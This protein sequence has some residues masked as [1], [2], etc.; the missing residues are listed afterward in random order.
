[1]TERYIT[2]GIE[3]YDDDF[4]ILYDENMTLEQ[5]HISLEKA[6][7]PC[8]LNIIKYEEK[9]NKKMKDFVNGN[10]N[11]YVINND[12]LGNILKYWKG[13]FIIKN[14]SCF[15]DSFVQCLIHSLAE[16]LF[17]KEEEFRKKNGLSILEIF[18]ENK[19][20]SQDS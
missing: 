7:G 13:N 2:I 15:R 11:I 17:K 14:N 5:F 18:K 4:K 9:K 20:N 12:N 19:N 10:T 1:M 3:K 16:T 8:K 6:I